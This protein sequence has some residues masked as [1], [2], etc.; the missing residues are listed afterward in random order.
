MPT[1]TAPSRYRSDKINFGRKFFSCAATLP[2]MALIAT[3]ALGISP[4]A[5][6]AID[7]NGYVQLSY[8]PENGLSDAQKL[9]LDDSANYLNSMIVGNAAGAGG[10]LV[11]TV[12]TVNWPG[13]GILASAGPDS[14]T[15][16]NANGIVFSTTGGS[17]INL[18][19]YDD[20]NTADLTNTMVHEYCHVLGLGTLW[21]ANNL[22]EVN[23]ASDPVDPGYFKY[24]GT[25]AL[26]AWQFEFGQ[27]SAESV[28]I[29]TQGGQGTAGGHWLRPDATGIVSV[30][31]GGDFQN[32]MMTGWDS[33]DLTFTSNVTI[34][35]LVDLGF[36]IKAPEANASG[37]YNFDQAFLEVPA[38]S[39]Y[40]FNLGRMGA[41]GMMVWGELIDGSSGSNRVVLNVNGDAVVALMAANTYSGGTTV[42]AGRLLI[43]NDSALGTGGVTVA[44]GI[45]DIGGLAIVAPTLTL[46]GGVIADTLFGTST[47]GSLTVT[48]PM[49][50]QA[51]EVYV[52]LSGASALNKTTDGTVILGAANDFTGATTVSGGTLLVAHA[53]ALAQ[54]SAVSINGGMLN[55]AGV[56][57]NATG[58]VVLTSGV[59]AGTG[60][61]S[62]ASLTLESGVVAAD[63]TGS[64]AVTKDTAGTV[65]LAGANSFKDGITVKDGV[66]V[67][68]AA[69]AL[70]SRLVERSEQTDGSITET[71]VSTGVVTLSGGTLQLA[72][73]YAAAGA[74]LDM[75]GGSLS[76]GT[77]TSAAVGSLAGAD[78]ISLENDNVQGVLLAV[79]FN[80]TDTAYSGRLTGTGSLQKVGAGNFTLTGDSDFTGGAAVAGGTLTMSSAKALGGGPV[81]VV[82]GTL[83]MTGAAEFAGGLT[84][85]GGIAETA[86]GPIT[87]QQGISV[88]GTGTFSPGGAGAATLS[89]SGNL[90][91][92]EAGTLRVDVPAGA[93]DRVNVTGGVT[94]SGG[95][96]KIG[97]GSVAPDFNVQDYVFLTSTAGISGRPL[98]VIGEVDPVTGNNSAYTPRQVVGAEAGVYYAVPIAYRFDLNAAGE[99][100]LAAGYDYASQSILSGLNSNEAAVAYA[101]NDLERAVGRDAN[102]DPDDVLLAAL[103]QVQSVSSLA[104]AYDSLMPVNTMTVSRSLTKQANALTNNFDRRSRSVRR[105]SILPGSIWTNYLFGDSYGFDYSAHPLVASNNNEIP[106]LGLSEEYPVTIWL[107]GGGSYWKGKADGFSPTTKSTQYAANIGVDYTWQNGHGLRTAVYS[108]GLLAGYSN[109]TD[110]ISGAGSRNEINAASLGIYGSAYY[111]GFFGNVLASYAVNSYDF[112]RDIN[113]GSMALTANASPDGG[114]YLGYINAGYEWEYRNWMHGPIV[115]LQYSNSTVDGYTENGADNQNLTVGKQT[116]DSLLAAIGWRVSTRIE[117]ETATFLPEVR[118]SYNHEFLNDGGAI[119]S[120]MANPNARPFTVHTADPGRDY[121]NVGIGVTVLLSETVSVSLD[122][123]AS[124]FQENTDPQHTINAM[125]RVSF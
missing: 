119:T 94:F 57:M 20:S 96:I 30:F 80:D 106:Y 4:Q 124:L 10:H 8:D 6:A 61:L 107:N 109:I 60:A 11:I 89:V 81:S 98:G 59:I 50:M 22:R 90:A 83:K 85:S 34:G 42:N 23:S 102:N 47:G 18:A 71:V 67:A 92:S 15:L 13:T 115:S 21:S 108:V 65:V 95:Y 66:L 69:G 63:I 74:E 9:A 79:G 49:D 117:T 1:T 62:A 99:G 86:S 39:A 53:D 72:H 46:T 44:G 122:Y 77:L 51:G 19:Y 82:G 105:G 5:G 123:D 48:S 45:L 52:N 97:A 70:S 25:N 113:I 24:L 36:K 78:N 91:F 54:S 26:F 41:K 38:A 27:T 29:E 55:I 75:A 104:E 56:T 116:F 64:G 33:G 16:A 111:N 103:N 40:D 37:V 76:F 31:S 3:G 12:S 120:S 58:G 14:E 88:R 68:G 110:K 112:K 28:P 7:P 17:G 118:I 73:T 121:V 125:V 84:V 114:Q 35:A 93:K 100:L 2:T 101:L 87:A 43:G 32:E